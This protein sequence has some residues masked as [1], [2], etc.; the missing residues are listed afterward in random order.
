YSLAFFPG[1][2]ITR[3]ALDEARIAARLEVQTLERTYRALG[4]EECV[5]SSGTIVAIGEILRA[6]EWSEGGVT[7]K[8]LR[9]LRKALVQ[10]GRVDALVKSIA[11]LQEERAPVLAGGVAILSALF[12]GLEIERMDVSLGALREGLIYDLLGRIRHEDV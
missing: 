12:D 5:G 6:N 3:E 8:G 7:A 11:G 9:K 10:A 4:W 2:E 1:G